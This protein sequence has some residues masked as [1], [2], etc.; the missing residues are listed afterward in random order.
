M[1]DTDIRKTVIDAGGHLR[2]RVEIRC[3]S[4]SDIT[5]PDPDWIVGS[6]AAVADEQSI[7]M[8][9][10]TGVWVDMMAKE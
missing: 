1:K 7:F 9:K 5:P 6:L 3:D 4:L 2:Y 8:L 10:S